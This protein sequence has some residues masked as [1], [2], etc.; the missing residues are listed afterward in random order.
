MN[1]AMSSW[2][3]LRRRIA[4]QPGAAVLVLGATGNAGRL[5]VQIARH[6]GAGHV[7]AAGRDA[8]RLAALAGL[9][10]DVTVSL[11]DDALGGAA[12][13]VDVVID[14]LWGA[15]AAAGHAPRCHRPRATAAARSTGSRSA[16]SPARPPRSRPPRCA[17]PTCGSWAAGRAR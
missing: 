7:V 14:Y 6:L 5:A 1:P 2:V 16:R 4:F 17:P 10:A 9:G 3:A 15:P 13:D 8:E 11:D 12:A